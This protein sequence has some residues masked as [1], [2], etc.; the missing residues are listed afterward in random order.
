MKDFKIGQFILQDL[1]MV[2]GADLVFAQI[3]SQQVRNRLGYQLD[4]ECHDV[5]AIQRAQ[6][7]ICSKGC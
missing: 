5:G 4:D 2:N 6:E 7:L 1:E 3:E